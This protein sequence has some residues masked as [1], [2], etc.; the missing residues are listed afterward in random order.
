M[1]SKSSKELKNLILI[2]A[3]G[4]ARSSIDVIED[5][6]EY[7]I[8]GLIGSTNEIGRQV[9]GYSVIDDDNDLANVISSLENKH[10]DVVGIIT[11]GQIKS[12]EVRA[13]LY[14]KLLDLKK[15]SKTIISS[16]SYVSRSAE[17]LKGTMIFHGAL[18][19]A[20]AR[21]K[22]NTIINSRALIEH[23]SQVGSHCH[24]ST[25]VTING[26]VLV[27]NGTFIG[28]GSIIKEGVK[29]GS[30]CIIGMGQKIMNNIEDNTIYK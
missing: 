5:N 29:I 16:R 17:I 8:L 28:S 22:E 10:G 30:N 2:G 11:V 20:N 15:V 3:G 19:N 14:K 7:N 25:D 6:N 27:G 1:K 26:G 4:H 12:Y 24:I 13:S 18:V 21:I 23:D 9:M